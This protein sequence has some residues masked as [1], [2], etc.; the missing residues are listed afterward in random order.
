MILTF[1][2][3]RNDIAYRAVRRTVHTTGTRM[4]TILALGDMFKMAGGYNLGNISKRA[5]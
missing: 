1:F 4:R 5:F 2:N 3:A